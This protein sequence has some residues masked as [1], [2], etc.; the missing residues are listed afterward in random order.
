MIGATSADWDPW[1]RLTAQQAA[2][3]G[4]LLLLAARVDGGPWRLRALIRFGDRLRAEVP[5]AVRVAM[6]AGIQTVIVTGDHLETATAVANAIGLPPGAALLGED[7]DKMS[8]DDLASRLSTIRLVARATPEHKLRLVR[9]GQAH[10]RSIAV[11]GDGVNDAPALE[12]A[13]VA[14]S[15]G[16]GT[17]VARGASD[18]VL[19]DDSFATMM[20][21]LR[22][23][24]RIVANVQKGL[25]F[26]VST[27]VALLGF[28]LIATLAGFGQPLLPLQILW[29]ELFIDLSTSVA[30]EQEA[31][32]PGAMDR[33]PRP[34]SL[35]LLDGGILRRI[36]GAGGFSAICAFAILL[37]H[38]GTVDHARWMAFTTLVLAQ[39]ARAYAN[40]SL[41]Q[42]VLRLA[43]NR[44]LIAACL[45]AVA[46]QAAIPLI[47]QLSGVFRAV[48]LSAG[49]WL[50]AV[51]VAVA[52]ALV[53]QAVRGSRRRV[54]VA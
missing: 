37:F 54:W 39:V 11:T 15:M 18:I 53:A 13:D 14:V 23:G 12:A 45:V 49:E 28:I 26:L 32:E 34:R 38:P 6:T 51:G 33:P 50:L 8:D 10:G 16:S 31:E 9:V 4:R 44:F 46:I 43:P 48:D 41:G 25:V 40:R 42:S 22:E 2:A 24:R 29:L 19:G 3:G 36:A 30:F 5:G 7:L 20:H 1:E 47:P 35:P 52:P 17:A 21:A 27:H